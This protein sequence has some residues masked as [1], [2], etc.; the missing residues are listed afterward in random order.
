MALRAVHEFIV[1]ESDSACQVLTENHLV[2]CVWFTDRLRADNL[3][4]SGPAATTARLA[5]STRTARGM[6]AGVGAILSSGG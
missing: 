6:E 2:P 3:A 5:Y 4:T 1:D